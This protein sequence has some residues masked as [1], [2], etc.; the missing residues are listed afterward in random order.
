LCFL[1]YTSGITLPKASRG[2]VMEVE[3]AIETVD[4]VPVRTGVEA[5]TRMI[6][7]LFFEEP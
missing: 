7:K 2:D 3:V 5:S 6:W 1:I 4:K